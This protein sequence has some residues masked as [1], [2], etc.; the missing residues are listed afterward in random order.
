MNTLKVK[1]LENEKK[2]LFLFIFTWVLYAIIYMTK[3]CYNG[4]IASIVAEGVFTKSQTGA[5]TAAFYLVYGIFQIPAGV[6]AD[7]YSPYKLVL[8]GFVGAA[9][10]NA[11][12]Y[13]NQDYRVMMGAWIFNGIIQAAVWPAMF[14][15]FST[16][17]APNHRARAVYYAGTAAT[18]GEAICYIVAGFVTRWQ[19]NF[20]ISMI[21]LA[22]SAVLWMV[23]Y[24]GM[25]KSMVCAE[26]PLPQKE[27]KQ[28]GVWKIAL[29]S[30]LVMVI[31][32]ALLRS[33]LVTG[34]KTLTPVMIMESYDNVSASSATLLNTILVVVGA[35]N[36]FIAKIVYPKFIKN[37]S[38]VLTLFMALTLPALAL[39]ML[40]GKIS[41]PLAFTG[42]GVV[43][44]M[45]LT[46]GLFC[47]SY[48]VRYFNEFG[49]GAFFAGIIN[50][51]AAF[52]MVLANYGFSLFADVFGWQASTQ[53]WFVVGVIITGLSAV[54]IPAWGRFL[55]KYEK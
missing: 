42:L 8:I 6:L 46:A 18:L 49:K 22:I 23:I 16:Q 55:K 26:I 50:A 32:V 53:M 31:V 9:I 5:I 17:L 30:G 29:S 12:I 33:M 1:Y 27:E 21:V 20:L 52:G 7:K 2:S 38:G 35:C 25:E 51:A 39:I 45:L 4:A 11:V 10:A 47:G 24:P 54:T 14:K 3:M 40:V 28:S 13:I 15:I 37:E 41:V 34:V 43:V 19:Y 36:V 48:N 44:V